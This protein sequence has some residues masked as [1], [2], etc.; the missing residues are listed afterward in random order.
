MRHRLQWFIHLRGH[1]IR[2]KDEHPAYTLQGYGTLY[3]FLPV[4]AQKCKEELEERS[5]GGCPVGDLVDY[6]AANYTRR[7][8]LLSTQRSYISPGLR[9]TAGNVSYVRSP[10][11]QAVARSL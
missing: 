4:K 9:G 2:K 10:C 7:A 8:E 3:L 1:R 5:V 6:I 11:C